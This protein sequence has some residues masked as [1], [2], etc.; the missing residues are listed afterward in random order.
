MRNWIFLNLLFLGMRLD[1][2]SHWA[3][4]ANLGVNNT[5]VRSRR[6]P[7]ST[8]ANHATTLRWG[9]WGRYFF[10]KHWAVRTEL[11]QEQRGWKEPTMIWDEPTLMQISSLVDYRYYFWT[12]P[13]SIEYVWGQS[14]RFYTSVGLAPMYQTA[15]TKYIRATGEALSTFLD[16]PGS[17]NK[18]IQWSGFVNMG[19]HYP[20]GAQWNLYG[21]TRYSLSFSEYEAKKRG[22]HYAYSLNLGA[23]Y[24]F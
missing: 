20:I 6:N 15:G 7:A 5:E 1:A 10:K 8:F 18:T 21:E 3:I 9:I 24:Q 13:V 12:M 2:Q 23:S 14:A 19:Y 16:N 22:Y 17:L 11:N 4:G